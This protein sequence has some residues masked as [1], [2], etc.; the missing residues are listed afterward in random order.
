ME[1]WMS[2]PTFEENKLSYAYS[3]E[4]HKSKVPE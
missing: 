3:R 1:I 2:Q 4:L